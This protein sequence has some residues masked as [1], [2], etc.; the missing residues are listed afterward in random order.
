[1]Q[2]CFSIW[3]QTVDA[4]GLERGFRGAL[5]LEF[6]NA[7]QF[8][9]HGRCARPG[10]ASPRASWAAPM[11]RVAAVAAWWAVLALSGG[12]Q[13]LSEEERL[14]EYQRRDH[15]WP[16]AWHPNTEGWVM[17]MERQAAQLFRIDD[18]R[19]RWSGFSSLLAR[20]LIARNFTALGYASTSAPG[21]FA[22]A[23]LHAVQGGLGSGG[24]Q[25]AAEEDDGYEISTILGPERPSLFG[26]PGALAEAVVGLK[27]VHEDFAG[28]ELSSAGIAY[29]VRVYRNGTSVL[30]HADKIQE[31]VIS[32]IVL[33][34]H[35]ADAE[36]WPVAVQGFDG[37]T[38]EVL[39]ER[40]GDMLLY[41]SAKVLHGRPRPLRGSWY[42]VAY[43]HYAPVDW[44]VTTADAM[45]AVPPQWSE[46]RRGDTRP[47]WPLPL[48][49]VVGAGLAED[50]V[51]H[52]C[53]VDARR[54]RAGEGA[55]LSS[56][57]RSGRATRLVDGYSTEAWP[58][59]SDLS[60]NQK[61]WLLL[62]AFVLLAAARTKAT[63]GN[64]EKKGV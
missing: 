64:S 14:L 43:F 26:A 48:L 28:V 7:A 8:R 27:A 50:C 54:H 31:H 10:R 1:M 4:D 5:R 35:S 17:A 40:P 59:A 63:R 29:G 55:V 52:W 33:V 56:A 24:E 38:A 39:L 15:R 2:E 57:A 11:P 16:A 41:E 9:G 49:R 34:G 13:S 53:A 6:R 30:M 18:R 32:S 36:P 25:L 58:S 60:K 61:G 37:Q 44:E 51:S 19:Q 45:F 22:A 3:G 23:M 21:G 12:C 62:M 46:P 47:S 42:A 20:G